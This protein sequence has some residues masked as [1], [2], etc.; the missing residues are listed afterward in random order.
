MDFNYT[1]ITKDGRRE[2]STLQAPN[3]LA[4][5]HILKDRGLLPILLQEQS[6]K[7]VWDIFKRIGTISLAEKINFVENLGIMLKAGISISRSLQ[8]L[9]KQTKNEKFK[10]I[11]IDLYSQIEQGTG[12]AEALARYPN[13]FTNIFLNMDQHPAHDPKIALDS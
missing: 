1:G 10:A 2:S 9:V 12:L 8:I 11:L 3:A 4:A 13:I 5:G 7:S 6:K